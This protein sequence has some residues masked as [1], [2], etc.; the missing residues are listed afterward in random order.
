MIT[1]DETKIKKRSSSK[2]ALNARG[3]AYDAELELETEE[4]KTL[5][6]HGSIVFGPAEY[7]VAETSIMKALQA[8]PKVDKLDQLAGVYIGALTS[9]D[10]LEFYDECSAFESPYAEYFSLIADMLDEERKSVIS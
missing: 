2:A 6:L 4:G 10:L 3:I 1:F 8:R 9:V 5:Y 7:S